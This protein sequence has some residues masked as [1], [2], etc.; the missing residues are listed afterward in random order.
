MVTKGT[1]VK[2]VQI[3]GGLNKIVY[4]K[5]GKSPVEFAGTFTNYQ[6]ALNMA[7]KYNSEL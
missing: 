1:E 6:D 3:P 2:V 7:E 5:G 4:V